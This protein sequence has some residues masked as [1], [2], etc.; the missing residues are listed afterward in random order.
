MYLNLIQLKQWMCQF[1]KLLIY[2]DF[3]WFC[4]VFGKVWCVIGGRCWISLVRRDLSL[5]RSVFSY[6]AQVKKQ[7]A[8]ILCK[9]P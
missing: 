5:M 6:G 9:M 4:T 1:C 3:V 7:P 2:K 8:L